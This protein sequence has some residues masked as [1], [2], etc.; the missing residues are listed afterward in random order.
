MN[1]HLWI[2]YLSFA[3]EVNPGEARAPRD[4]KNAMRALKERPHEV[5]V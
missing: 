2:S 3:M 1:M 4:H 5:D